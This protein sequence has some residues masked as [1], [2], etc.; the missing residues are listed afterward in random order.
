[1]KS[2]VVLGI[3]LG[4]TNCRVAQVTRE[5]AVGKPLRF[6]TAMDKGFEPFFSRLLEACSEIVADARGEGLKVEALGMGCPG[7]IGPRGDVVV[8][9]NLPALNGKPLGRLLLENLGLKV[10]VVNDANA[11]AWGE[12]TCG[13][14]SEFP[15][16][17]AITL[18]TGVGSGL[19][20]EGRLWVGPDGTACE[21]GHLM[22]EPEGRP[23]GCGA[24]GC[25]E[26][27]ASASGIVKSVQEA[28]SR[29]VPSLLS[30][31]PSGELTSERVA[32]AAR[33]GDRV[34]C[35]ALEEAG[36]RLGQVFAGLANLLNLH[37]A[38]ITGGAAESLDLMRPV[39]EREL[40][41]RAFDIPARR[42]RIVRGT[43]GDNAGI[44]GAARLALGTSRT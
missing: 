16:F 39:M 33:R 34:A 23:C 22:V 4:G 19:V 9:P 8:S 12:G 25:L 11:I 32:E 21:A 36:R 18:G 20:L 35:S 26:Q 24:R 44:I 41:L 3:D 37:G 31:T 6:P 38:V 30:Q 27:Y 17:V 10:T 43:L 14:G 1:M 5:G 29:N 42:L 40:R 7:V 13:A 15:S 28:L 2:P